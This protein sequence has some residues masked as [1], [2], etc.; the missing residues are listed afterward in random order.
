MTFRRT[1]CAHCR[2]KFSPE[3]PSQIV[4]AECAEAY[5][6]AKREKE[7]RAQAKAD[8]MAT[9]VERAE[10]RRRKEAM[11]SLR[12]LLAEAQTAFNEFIRLR[13]A[14]KPCICCGMPFEPMKPGGSMDAGHFRSRSTAPQIRFNEDNVFGQ[15]KNCNRPGGT[16]Y[17]KFRV[18]VL[19]RIGPER[20]EVIETNNGV[21]KWTHDEVRGIRD[22][23]RAKAKQLKKESAE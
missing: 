16:T 20:L 10:T 1:R 6:I 4:H 12:E 2:A 22:S 3:R 19:A 21:H 5:A 13:D 8:R 14:G 9:K 11:K 17:S 7:E 18:G 23:Y 15:R